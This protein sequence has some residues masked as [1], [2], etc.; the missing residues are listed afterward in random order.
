MT[1]TIKA[2]IR[3]H[4]NT[5][6]GPVFQKVDNAMHWINHYPLASAIGFAV[7]YPLDSNLSGRLHYSSFEQ[8]WAGNYLILYV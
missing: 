3:L 7:T 4:K 1:T 8:L 2:F 5:H 6:L